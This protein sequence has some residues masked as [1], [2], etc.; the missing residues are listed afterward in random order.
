[1]LG[2]LGIHDTDEHADNMKPH[3][4]PAMTRLM[5]LTHHCAAPRPLVP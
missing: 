5:I 3:A 4:R 2:M 1:M